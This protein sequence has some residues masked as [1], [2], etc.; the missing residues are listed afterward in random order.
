LQLGITTRAADL[1]RLCNCCF[2]PSSHLAAR[3]EAG[4]LKDGLAV[5]KHNE[6]RDA[7]HAKTCRQF[8][9]AL[10]IDFQNESASGHLVR[11]RFYFGRGHAA[12]TAPFRPEIDEHRDAGFAGDLVESGCVHIDGFGGW[13]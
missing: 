3:D 6:V 11:Q 8:R 9:V 10:G 1:I 2:E 4:L 5:P 7:L 13:G 12:G